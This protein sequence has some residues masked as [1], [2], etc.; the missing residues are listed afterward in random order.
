[1]LSDMRGKGITSGRRPIRPDGMYYRNSRRR[2]VGRGSG[3]GLR[4]RLGFNQV[5][6]LG[7]AVI[8]AAV[9]YWLMR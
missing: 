3:G 6:L 8:V 2:S 4:L 1:M 9:V 5:V 7:V